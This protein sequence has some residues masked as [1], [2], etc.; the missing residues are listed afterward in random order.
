MSY[1]TQL[2][3]IINAYEKDAPKVDFYVKKIRGNKTRLKKKQR[4][5]D[6]IKV[7]GAE[8]IKSK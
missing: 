1:V 3:D 8:D 4:Q 2:Y 6:R 5:I 7:I